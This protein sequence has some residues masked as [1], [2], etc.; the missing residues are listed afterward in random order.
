[1]RRTVQQCQELRMQAQERQ[2]NP[3]AIDRRIIYPSV[4]RSTME[5]KL[6]AAQMMRT[7]ARGML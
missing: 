4:S 3:V 7:L 5:V 1:V 6:K 2:G